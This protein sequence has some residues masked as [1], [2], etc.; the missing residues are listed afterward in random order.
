M[1]KEDRYRF[2]VGKDYTTITVTQRNHKKVILLMNHN[3]AEI[4]QRQSY[5]ISFSSDDQK[6]RVYIRWDTQNRISVARWVLG[7]TDPK[8]VITFK[9]QNT[10][11]FRDGN[12]VIIPPGKQIQNRIGA[13]KN[14]KSQVRGVT[15]YKKYN[16]WNGQVMHKGKNHNV[17]YHEDVKE[18]EQRVIAKRKELLEYSFQDKN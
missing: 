9:N 17:G 18:I 1:R 16:K 4:I 3:D 10:L 14:S 8:V 13:Q 2:E 6:P 15:W 11:D 7:L 12:L 5:N